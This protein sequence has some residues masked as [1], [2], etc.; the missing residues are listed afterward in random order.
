MK[1]KILLAMFLGAVIL[2]AS[3]GRQFDPYWRIQDFRVLAIKG[4]PVTIRPG[5]TARL[6]ALI[7]SDGEPVSY[8]WDWCPVRVT[9]QNRFECPF[10]SEDIQALL[11]QG[12]PD[13]TE[14]PSGIDGTLLNF[15]LGTEPVARLFNPLPAAAILEFCRNIQ[16]QLSEALDPELAKLLPTVDCRRGYEITV[17]LTASSGGKEIIASKR[18]TLWTGSDQINTNPRILS[19]EIRPAN[20]RDIAKLASQL[21]WVVAG[22]A[23]DDQWVVLPE[24]SAMPIVVGVPFEVRSL[25]DPETVQTWQPHAPIGSETELLDPEREALAYRWFTTLGTLSDSRRIFREN[26]NTLE[27]ASVTALTVSEEALDACLRR[28]DGSCEVTVWTVARDG[29]LGLDWIERKLVL[30]E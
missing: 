29:R 4:D 17:R 8:K 24:D 10:T 30:S 15:D 13:G 5:Q 20:E 2:A 9:A 1:K 27:E 11:A 28:P 19:A 6:S 14:I 25:V 18:L 12:L 16:R 26:V 21:D 3:C 7:H 22:R 23:H